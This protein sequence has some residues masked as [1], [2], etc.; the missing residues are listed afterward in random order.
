MTR[1][2]VIRH[3]QKM[4]IRTPKSSPILDHP[5][6][7]MKSLVE[8]NDWQTHHHSL[9]EIS[10]D[11]SGYWSDYYISVKWQEEHSAI[12]ITA[13][14][15]IYVIDQQRTEMMDLICRLN[16][17]VWMGH[18]NLTREE[19]CLMFRHTTPLRGTG[20]ATLEQV[21]DLIEVTVAECEKYYPALFQLAIG[22]ASASSA[23]E[24]VLM[25]TV[26]H[27]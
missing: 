14:L 10:V 7:I 24:T 27:A 13:L 20:G 25:E 6:V 15:D 21:I 9:N 11:I 2:R 5:I 12:H 17:R 22:S 8:A 16:E 23:T 3:S 18:F 26:G 1:Y 19:G 4:M